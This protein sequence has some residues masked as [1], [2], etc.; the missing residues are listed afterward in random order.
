MKTSFVALFA[1]AV[2]LAG[3]SAQE[4]LTSSGTVEGDEPPKTSNEGAPTDETTPAQGTMGNEDLTA[5]LT[6]DKTE[7][8][9]A[10]KPADPLAPNKPAGA[11]I[12]ASSLAGQYVGTIEI[13]DHL[14]DS[15]RQQGTE[16]QIKEFEKQ[17]KSAK[18]ELD[19]KADG[20]YV[21]SSNAMG[22]KT[23]ETGKWTYDPKNNTVT[24]KK[25]DVSAETRARLKERGMTD[26][27]ID[28]SQNRP[29]IAKVSDDGRSITYTGN[30]SGPGFVVTFTKK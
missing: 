24:I 1:L 27:Q 2:L 18:I 4:T 10:Q 17:L 6:P 16:E 9:A 15:M 29:V 12:D 7:E 11:R 5:T 20:T 13:P 22:A 25:P 14:L 19:L 26:A 21:I 23:T 3:C 30:G 8:S 28:E